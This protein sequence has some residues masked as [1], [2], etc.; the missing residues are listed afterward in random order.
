MDQTGQHA[1]IAAWFLIR[2]IVATGAS[3]ATCPFK[4]PKS[5]LSFNSAAGDAGAATVCGKSLSSESPAW[6]S[7]MRDKYAV[8]VKFGFGRTSHGRTSWS[9]ANGSELTL[10]DAMDQIV[11]GEI[12]DG[13]TIML[14]QY[15][16]LN[17]FS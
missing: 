9:A 2:G 1:R 15:A 4:E 13:K 10:D 7:L 16:K 3:C 14:L 17:L 12:R 6:L 8:W 5:T 11:S